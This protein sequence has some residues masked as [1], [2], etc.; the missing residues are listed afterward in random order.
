VF[1]SQH[2]QK[3]SR[4]GIAWILRKYQARATDP[5]LA[6]AQ[7]SP[8]VLRHSRAMHLYDASVP[9]PYIRDILGHVDLSTTDIYARASTEA[10]RKTLEAVYDN[11]VSAD[12][13]EWNQDN[14]LLTWLASL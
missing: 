1:F 9:L 14:E 6:D 10:K 13:P 12:L 4:G 8:H 2:H 11:V 3:L 5:A 7:L